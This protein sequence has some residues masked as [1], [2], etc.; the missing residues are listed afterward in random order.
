MSTAPDSWQIAVDIGNTCLKLGAFASTAEL[1]LPQPVET[2]VLDSAFWN[3][4]AL[5][6]WVARLGP[7]SARHSWWLASVNATA[8]DRLRTWLAA[9]RPHDRTVSVRGT[10]L[11][12]RVAVDEPDRVGIDRLLGILAAGRL[13]AA[14]QPAVVVDLGTAIKANLLDASGAFAGGAIAPGMQLAA[15]ALHRQTELLPLIDVEQLREA[16]AAV[17]LN[18]QAALA[19]GL[20]W[21]ALGTVRELIHRLTPPGSDAPLVVLTGGDAGQVAPWLP[22]SV[23]HR[24]HLVLSGIALVMDSTP[25]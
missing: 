2:L 23:L 17:G 24:P 21:G 11:P 18:T 16:P 14:G 9:A 5:A 6:S 25:P 13:V 12:L 20:Y 22:A 19:S 3:A 4:E 15:R 1:P 10:D 8:T 7:E